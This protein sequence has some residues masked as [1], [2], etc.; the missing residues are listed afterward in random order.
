MQNSALLSLRTPSLQNILP[1]NTS[2][3]NIHSLVTD[4]PLSKKVSK[5]KLNKEETEFFIDTDRQLEHCLRGK[6]S[7][8]YKKY[9]L[10]LDKPERYVLV[11]TNNSTKFPL[12]CKV[13]TIYRGNEPRDY[14][15]FKN[16]GTVSPSSRLAFDFFCAMSSTRTC[17][18]NMK[19]KKRSFG[20]VEYDIELF[21]ICTLVPHLIMSPFIP[22][23]PDIICRPVESNETHESKGD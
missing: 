8:S 3:P 10:P 6:A 16:Q 21:C 1:S 14:V 9:S 13:K 17:S 7:L 18:L 12:V 19:L 2:T 15:S 20:I 5:C 4:L 22:Q 23:T 11:V